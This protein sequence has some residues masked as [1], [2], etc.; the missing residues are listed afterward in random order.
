M[1]DPQPTSSV[2]DH[3]QEAVRLVEIQG[4]LAQATPAKGTLGVRHSFRLFRLL[5][6]F[7]LYRLL[8]GLQR[9][10]QACQDTGEAS[11]DCRYAAGR[12]AQLSSVGI[13]RNVTDGSGATP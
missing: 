2:L 10:P 9:P 7:H 3:A 1:T 11:M 13:S 5:R 12:L 6:L 8:A 4:R